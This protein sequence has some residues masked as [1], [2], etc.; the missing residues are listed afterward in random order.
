[1]G[2]AAP[3]FQCSKLVL[4]SRIQPPF[5]RGPHVGPRHRHRCNGV[6]CGGRPGGQGKSCGLKLSSNVKMRLT[7]ISSC[8]HG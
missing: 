6:G 4:P 1:M 7:A 3:C 2:I 8:W 5:E